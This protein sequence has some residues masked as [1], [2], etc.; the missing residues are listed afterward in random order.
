MATRVPYRGTWFRIV[1]PV[2][3]ML[4]LFQVLF[5]AL[6]YREMSNAVGGIARARARATSDLA[7]QTIES[8]MRARHGG[9]LGRALDRLGRDPD[10]AAIRVLDARGKVLVSARL[11]DTQ[12]A[13]AHTVQASSEG[14]AI[15]DA[16]MGSVVHRVTPIY[17]HTSCRECHQPGV[18]GLLD[19][20]ITMARQTSGLRTWAALTATAGFL[21]V[22]GS[23]AAIGIAVT[24]LILRPL[25]HL[26][27]L[28]NRVRGGDLSVAMHKVGTREI[29][30]V[31]DGFNAMVARLRNAAK[32][33][34]EARG[35]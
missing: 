11:N 35:R 28:M 16:A 3:V 23:L 26:T 4:V 22:V 21:Q 24:I 30:S 34:E 31:G 9:D 2:G 14:D 15:A 10:V 13:P 29:D 19:V 27:A 25:R 20:D 18:I 5:A 12:P 17:S 32:A 1:L 7:M 6:G 8:R 33:T